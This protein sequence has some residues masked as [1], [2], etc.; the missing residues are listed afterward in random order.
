MKGRTTGAQGSD[1]TIW[2]LGGLMVVVLAAAGGLIAGFATSFGGHL[3]AV[4][5]AVAVSSNSGTTGATLDL[6]IVTPDMLGP[7]APGPAYLP[8]NFTVPAHSTVKVTVT[9]FDGATPLTGPLVKYSKVTGTVGGVMQV[10][11]LD[12]NDPNSTKGAVKTLNYLNPSLVGHTLTIP[13][14]GINVP[15]AGQ[16]RVTFVIKTGKPGV[17]QWEC[18]DPCGGGSNGLGAP[19]GEEGFMTGTMTVAG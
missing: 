13:R 6:A 4:Q 15:M 11:P 7:N 16:A 18:M 2:V 9:D 19:M 17:Y 1:P 5:T 14:L 12:P 10:Q 8:S 3:K